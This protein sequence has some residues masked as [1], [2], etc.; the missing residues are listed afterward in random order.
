[1]GK[2]YFFLA[3][4]LLF[5]VP[6]LEAAKKK[7]KQVKSSRPAELVGTKEQRVQQNT[8]AILLGITQIN[9]EAEIVTAFNNKELVELKDGD[10]YRIDQLRPRKS[11]V[12]KS[13]SKAKTKMQIPKV[14]VKH[15]YVKYWV[16]EYLDV[17]ARDHFK[18]FHKQFLA[19]SGTRSLWLQHEMTRKGSP[20]Y[21]PYAAKAENPLE[22]SLHPRG[23]VVDISRAG[24]TAKE[25]KWIRDRLIKDKKNGIEFEVENQEELSGLETEPIEEKVCYH[26]LV[27][28][29]K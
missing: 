11:P 10:S 3:I 22:E 5:F 1:M 29:K 12:R 2:K 8:K 18:E 4:L 26:I 25:I 6:H 19:T 14:E 15:I 17:F 23:I 7:P 9:T 20:Y 24:M 13:K 16:K 27:F 21:T 28:P